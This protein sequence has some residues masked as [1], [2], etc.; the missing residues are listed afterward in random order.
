MRSLRVPR[1]A[2]AMA[3]RDKLRGQTTCDEIVLSPACNVGPIASRNSSPRAPVSDASSLSLGFAAG[4]PHG[5][6]DPRALVAEAEELERVVVERRRD[7]ASDA[8]LALR[9]T[10]AP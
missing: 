7:P 10:S 9:P 1:R 4:C 8:G 2:S 5:L 6:R 3:V